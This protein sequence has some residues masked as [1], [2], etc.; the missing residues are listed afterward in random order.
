MF[1]LRK[2]ANNRD[3]RRLFFA[4]RGA[5]SRRVSLLVNSVLMKRGHPLTSSSRVRC[6]YMA[7]PA[8]VKP[9]IKIKPMGYSSMGTLE[10]GNRKPCYRGNVSLSMTV[11]FWKQQYAERVRVLPFLLDSSSSFPWN[12][13]GNKVLTRSWSL[14]RDCLLEWE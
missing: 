3:R 8:P 9:A 2:Q 14:E 12:M 1:M 6:L 13:L 5:A 10:R 11:V 7:N 4:D